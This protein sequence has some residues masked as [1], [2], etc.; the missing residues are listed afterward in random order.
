[1]HT[2]PPITMKTPIFTSWNPGRTTISVP[3]KPTARAIQRVACAGSFKS[4]TPARAINSGNVNE[5][6]VASPMGI[7]VS[8]PN[9]PY[10]AIVLRRPR[11]T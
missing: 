6:A 7:S 9:Q 10:I 4:S 2:P 11:E 5:I 1:M 3:A 8:P